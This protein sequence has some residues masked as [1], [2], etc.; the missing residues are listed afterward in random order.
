MVIFC[1]FINAGFKFF[2][3]LFR[4]YFNNSI[5]RILGVEFNSHFQ[6]TKILGVE[7]V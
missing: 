6:K 7:L 4:L 5:I 3:S 1:K 2:I